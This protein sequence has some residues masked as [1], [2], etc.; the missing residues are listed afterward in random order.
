MADA[1]DVS[2]GSS[3]ERELVYEELLDEARRL[4]EERGVKEL[5]V[6]GQDTSDYG[7]DRYGR[8]RIAEL[9]AETRQRTP[10]T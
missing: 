5:I 6:V 3:S 10:D 7:V 8:P 4:V 1:D 2:S 9:L